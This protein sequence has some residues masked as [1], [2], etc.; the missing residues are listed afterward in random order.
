MASCAFVDCFLCICESLHTFV[1]RFLCICELLHSFVD[2]V[3]CICGFETFLTCTRRAQ[4]STNRWTPPTVYS[5][6]SDNKHTVLT[7]RGTIS[8]QP[9]IE[10]FLETLCKR[11]RRRRTFIMT[12]S[13]AHSKQWWKSASFVQVSRCVRHESCCCGDNSTRL[14]RG[15]FMCVIRETTSTPAYDLAKLSNIARHSCIS[16]HM[17]CNQAHKYSSGLSLLKEHTLI[18][19]RASLKDCYQY[20]PLPSS[21]T[22]LLSKLCLSFRVLCGV[23]YLINTE[24]W[25]SP[26]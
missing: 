16:I 8:L 25:L 3:L 26:I 6:Q 21:T 14:L 13:I 18:L 5:S 15:V 9:I 7:N 10:S 17:P 19:C 4:E 12:A 11:P 20:S 24:C 1:D 23:C 2:R 22:A